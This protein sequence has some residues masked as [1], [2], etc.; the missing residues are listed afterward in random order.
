MLLNKTLRQGV[1]AMGENW[2]EEPSQRNMGGFPLTHQRRP[3]KGADTVGSLPGGSEGFKGILT[4]GPCETLWGSQSPC[5]S[6][7]A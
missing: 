6:E 2:N 1:D 4:M 7:C 5:L 3:G